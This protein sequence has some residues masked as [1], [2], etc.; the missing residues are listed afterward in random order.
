MKILAIDTATEACSVALLNGDEINQEIEIQPTGHSRLV[1]KMVDKVLVDAGVGLES[2]D[3][4]AVNNGPGSFT[5]VRIGLGVTQGL[6]YGA[7]LPVIGVCS[8]EVLAVS[9]DSGLVM[10]AIDARMNQ[11]YCSLYSVAGGY[12]PVEKFGP[13]VVRPDQIPFELEEPIFGLGSGWDAY[14][15]TI[16][17]G[18]RHKEVQ[19]MKDKYPQAKNLARVAR[20]IGL[21]STTEP[22]QLQASYIRNEIVQKP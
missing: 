14:A 13:I 10:P 7:H 15:D 16:V 20:S 9:I 2:L 1:L 8:L 21:K 12:R 4:I 19:V 3:L 11:I 5:G 22:C 18:I 6:A 17:S